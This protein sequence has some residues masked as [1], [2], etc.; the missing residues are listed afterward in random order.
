M[1][2]LLKR[3]RERIGTWGTIVPERM[4]ALLEFAGKKVLDVGCSSGSY[5]AE[6]RNKGY[7]AQGVDALEDE[8]WKCIGEE[9]FHVAD[10]ASLAFPDESF[11]T[12][13][14][15]EV[16]EHVEDAES[17]LREFHRVAGQNLILSVP[18]GE[19]P[20][21]Y[22]R[23]ARVIFYHWI[24]R[25]HVNF[26]SRR[27]LERSLVSCGFKI[28]KVLFFNQIYPEMLFFYTMRIPWKY[29]KKLSRLFRKFPFRRD[30]YSTMLMVC[31]KV[32][33]E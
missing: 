15:F 18:N 19:L 14:A 8:N 10:A 24:D 1:T 27:A 12:I 23:M 7:D 6:L 16:L 33:D 3:E 11:D 25:S 28:E 9:F 4:N 21:P 30:F 31:S 13:S 2:E 17:V 5:V 20:E 26:F 29:S 22:F 32:K